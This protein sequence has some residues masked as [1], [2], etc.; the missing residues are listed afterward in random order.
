[1]PLSS[2]ACSM[3]IED[4][5]LKVYVSNTKII[6]F[7]YSQLH[8]FDGDN[9][10]GLVECT[11]DKLYQVADWINV[12]SGMVHE[13][14]KI[15]TGE[16]FVNSIYF[17]PSERIEGRHDKK[18][19]VSISYLTS[20]QISD[21][22][23]SDTYVRFKVRDIMKGLGIKGKKN[24]KNPNYPH[25]S[26]VPYKYIS[27]N[28]END[29]REIR[30]HST[31]SYE[32]VENVSFKNCTAEELLGFITEEGLVQRINKKITKQDLLYR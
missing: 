32:E 14:D 4:G 17:Y 3:R 27:L 23:Y 29:K 12:R 24:G 7:K 15:E 31:V 1:M 26:Q 2:K 21:I 16:P 28:L 8:I 19:L 20:E 9:V 11:G 5:I 30:L 25:S 6:K 13:Y 18:D 10:E 22:N